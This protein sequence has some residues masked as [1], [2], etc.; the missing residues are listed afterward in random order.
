MEAL[1]A[2]EAFRP[3]RLDDIERSAALALAHARRQQRVFVDVWDLKQFSECA[4]CFI[5][6]RDRLH[7]MN[8]EQR[9]LP[10]IACGHG[11]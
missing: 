8:L 2:E 5:A 4:A 7:A 1:A 3:P 10:P 11:Q 9:I 6:R